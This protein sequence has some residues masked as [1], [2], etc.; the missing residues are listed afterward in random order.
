MHIALPN[1]ESSTPL[2]KGLMSGETQARQGEAH[3]FD[4]DMTTIGNEPEG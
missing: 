2:A 4:N 3:Q 1:A